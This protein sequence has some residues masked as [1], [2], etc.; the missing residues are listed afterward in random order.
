MFTLSSLSTEYVQVPVTSGMVP[1]IT[2]PTTGTV[3]MAFL[4]SGANPQTSDWQAGSW[5]T[6]PAGG[7]FAQCLVGPSGGVITL[8]PGVYYQ[9]IKIVLAPQT[10][11]IPVGQLEVT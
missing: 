5:Y 8:A 7:Y 10:I 3:S 1:D 6:S 4:T 9:W 2:N 11:V